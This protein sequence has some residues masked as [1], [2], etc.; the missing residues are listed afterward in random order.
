VPDK[1]AIGAEL[2]VVDGVVLLVDVSSSV[3]DGAS[4]DVDVTGGGT[5]SVLRGSEPPPPPLDTTNAAKIPANTN[6]ATIPATNATCVRLNR[7]F[8]TGGGATGTDGWEA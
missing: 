4:V 8:R 1:P 5:A 6:M 3:A 7:D 2:V